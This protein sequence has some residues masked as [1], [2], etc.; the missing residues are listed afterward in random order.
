MN[1]FDILKITILSSVLLAVFFF[2]RRLLFWGF[3]PFLPHHPEVAERIAKEIE[4]G[5]DGVF[6]CLGY[7]D[8]GL[9]SAIEKKFP[10]RTLI[11]VDIGG[12]GHM[13][14]RLQSFLKGSKVKIVHSSYY[15]TDLRRASVVFCHLTP[16]E[17]REMCKKL[18][19]E[20]PTDSI[21]VSDGFIV[22]YMEPVKVIS[23]EPKKKWYSFLIRHKKVLTIKEKEHTRDGNIYFYQV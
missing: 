22:P 5:P 23:V 6:Y 18:K 20:P 9:L 21:V 7:D 15:R 19:L 11:G 17:L 2:F 16:E 1:W 4:L 3:T 14:S 13:F 8:S 10:G 12:F